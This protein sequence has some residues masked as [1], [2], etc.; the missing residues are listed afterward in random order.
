MVIAGYYDIGGPIV[1]PGTG[2]DI[3]SRI[4]S[5][6]MA[7]LVKIGLNKG[8]FL[9]TSLDKNSVSSVTIII[10]TTMAIV[11]RSWSR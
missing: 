10:N 11:S 7:N 6:I 5:K 3:L 1:K 9:L 8:R 4:I 2:N